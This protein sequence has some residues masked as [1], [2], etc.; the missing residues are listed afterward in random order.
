MEK[1]MEDKRGISTLELAVVL[2]LIAIM[3]TFTVPFLGS[4]LRHYR[5]VGAAREMTSMMQNARLLAVKNNEDSC[6]EFDPTN[7]RYCIKSDKGANGAWDTWNGGDDTIEKVVSFGDKSHRDIGFGLQ[8][9]NA[10]GGGPDASGGTTLSIPSDYVSFTNN[11][12]EFNPDGTS[13]SGVA[14]ITDTYETYA[15]KVGYSAT[16]HVQ[17]WYWNAGTG[18]WVRK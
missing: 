18:K 4:W 17:I 13:G 15:V 10:P 11:R 14:Y 2:A 3:A 5:V 6:V 9:A 16:G 7:N 8:S 1:R 12:C